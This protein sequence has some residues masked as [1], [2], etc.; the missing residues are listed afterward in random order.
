M[1]PS[2]EGPIEKAKVLDR[3]TL[4]P[5]SIVFSVII[6]FLAAWGWLNNQFVAIGTKIDASIKA[7]DERFTVYDRRME[8]VE[9]KSDNA[10]TRVDEVLWVSEFRRMNPDMKIPAATRRD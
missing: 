9:A 6:A 2:D 10:W 1:A 3:G 4:V 7:T 5:I 8:R